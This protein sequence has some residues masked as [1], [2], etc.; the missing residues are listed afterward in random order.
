MQS[1]MLTRRRLLQGAAFAGVSAFIVGS[2]TLPAPASAEGS[3]DVAGIQY[4]FMMDVSKCMDCRKCVDACRT[5]NGI[6][7]GMPDRRRIE[8]FTDKRGNDVTISTSCMHCADPSCLR[9]CPAGAIA[10]GDAGI[11]SV[12][13]DECIGCKY[14]YEACPYEVP[15]YNA[16]GMDK[17][18]CCLVAGVEPGGTPNCVQ[19][20]IFG[21]L[22][23]GPIDELKEK[24]PNAIVIS[25]AN[26]P[27][28]LI[29]TSI[30]N[31]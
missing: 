17:C 24:W 20:C 2:V 5:A 4:G 22:E 19:A 8:H 9:V 7:E 6:A 10:K 3:S 31:A 30:V 29:K 14:C 16:E 21:A 27:S 18:D 15:R 12:N 23:Y 25:E 11:V 1:D 26:G 28:C 13:K